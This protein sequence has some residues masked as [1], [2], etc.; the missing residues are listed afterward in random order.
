MDDA[1]RLELIT[2]AV[3]YCRSA[4]ACGMPAS[5]YAKALR[6]PVHFLWE[7]RFG[8][9]MRAAKY[10]SIGARG[11]KFGTGNLV[12]DHAIPFRFLQQKLMSW[13]PDGGE[14]LEA[15]LARYDTVVLISKEENA[16]LNSAG[17]GRTMPDGWDKTEPLARYRAVGI[18]LEPNT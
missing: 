10:R 17:L 4:H 18:E 14:A 11:L 8:S 2:M 12:Y 16:K 6:E 13:D 1:K 7:R 5:C 15:I 9:K 3:R